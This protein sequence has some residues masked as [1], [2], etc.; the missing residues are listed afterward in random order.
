M[1]LIPALLFYN[2][3][4]AETVNSKSDAVYA[5]ARDF[6]HRGVPIDGVGLQMHVAR[7]HADVGSI[8]TNIK[9]FTD[10]GM[11]VHITE[12]DIALPLDAE[13][14]PR[15]DDLRQQADM[16]REIAA[17][18]L[19]HAGCTAIQTWG[20]TDKYSWIGSHSKN[21]QGA[22][23]LFDAEYRPKPAYYALK[24]AIE[25]ARRRASGQ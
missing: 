11:Q 4:E 1:K 14:R 20:F 15:P 6:R 12:M 9:R 21:T 8:A 18:C 19:T 5:M 25:T 23:L 10:L 13:G 2:E 22:A 7:Q 17:T 3:A 24:N 16:Y